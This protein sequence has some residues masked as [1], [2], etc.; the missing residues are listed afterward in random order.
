MRPSVRRAADGAP[1]PGPVDRD[2]LL[3][4]RRS[5]ADTLEPR[6][7]VMGGA[8]RSGA[9]RTSRRSPRAAIAAVGVA[10]ALTGVGSPAA[11]TTSAE[12]SSALEPYFAQTIE[13]TSCENGAQCATVKA[14][15]DWENPAAGTDIDLA[16]ARHRAVGGDPRGSL[17][18]NPGGPGGSGVALVKNAPQFVEEVVRRSFDLVGWDPRGVGSSSAVDCYESPDLD[19]F[20]FGFPSGEPGSPEWDAEIDQAGADFSR[21]CAENTGELL[22]YVDTV[23]TVRDLDLLRHL[24]GDER[25]NYFGLSYGT[26]IG[27]VYADLFP[28]NVGRMALDAVVDPSL[29]AFE[30]V[31]GQVE[32]F[33]RALRGYLAACAA[34]ANCP[35]SGDADADIAAIAELYDELDRN[36]L[37]H[38]DGRLLSSYVLDTAVKNALYDEATWQFITVMFL[39]VRAG[40]TGLVFASADA[41]YGRQN[42][43]TYPGNFVEAFFAIH[44]LD[45]AA[46]TDPAVLREQAAILAKITPLVRS[47]DQPDPVCAN[48]QRPPRDRV[49][50]VTGDGAAP[51]LLIG[52][53][54]DPATPYANA[55]AVGEQLESG[56]LISYDG[57]DHIAYDEGDRCVND[58]VNDYLVTGDAP[59]TDL[60]CGF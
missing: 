38:T 25:L 58:A 24:V 19:E 18:I 9:A 47:D 4:S 14:P 22:G 26:K 16:L 45:Y 44:C 30:V 55:V 8:R 41:Y 17:F 56:V 50:P 11:G 51:I 2:L 57:Q 1:V 40:E 35:F 23:S 32:G 21:A 36:P 33:D 42:D 59:A 37:R 7:R 39:Q 12:A 6:R 49:Q 34:T 27:A 54:G 53:L 3:F 13:W 5:P 10:V 52:T 28:E 20:L 48:W 29:S 43:G 15:L 46:E 60:K 31:R